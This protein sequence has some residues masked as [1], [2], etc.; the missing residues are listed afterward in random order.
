VSIE[1]VKLLLVSIDGGFRMIFLFGESIEAQSGG[2]EPPLY[3][4]SW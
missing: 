4:P 2:E 1:K 3:E